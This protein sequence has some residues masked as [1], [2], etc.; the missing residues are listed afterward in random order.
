MNN[1]LAAT[2][3]TLP[4][5]EL[6]PVKFLKPNQIA[7]IDEALISLGEYGELRL[8]VEKGCLRFLVTHKSF[9]ALK[10]TPG[11]ILDESR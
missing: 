9:D 11:A 6:P 1:H 10:W 5:G 2:K 3:K 7:M 4:N 8:V